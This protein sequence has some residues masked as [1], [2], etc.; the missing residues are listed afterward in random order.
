MS[1]FNLRLYN[2]QKFKTCKKENPIQSKSASN[3]SEKHYKEILLLETNN[4]E[5]VQDKS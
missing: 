2:L 3:F 4:V 1:L 5:E